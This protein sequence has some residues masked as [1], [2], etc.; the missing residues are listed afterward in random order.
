MNEIEKLAVEGA[1][2][3]MREASAT[4][5]AALAYAERAGGLPQSGVIAARRKLRAADRRLKSIVRLRAASA[6]EAEC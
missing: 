2:I 1:M 5:A 6:G 3:D 4:L